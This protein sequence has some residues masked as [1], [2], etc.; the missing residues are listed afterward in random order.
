MSTNQYL[1]ALSENAT[2]LGMRLQESISEHTRDLQQ[3]TRVGGLGLGAGS[4]YL[5]GEARAANDSGN[6]NW[7]AMIKKQLESSSDREKL[8]AMRRLIAMISKNNNSASTYFPSVVKLVASPSLEIRKLVYIYLLHYSPFH[9]DLALLSINTFQR[10]LSDPSPLI[11][12]MALRVLSGM[13]V[14]MLAGVV[15]LGT[16]KCAA[17][18]SPYVRKVA[19]LAI[20]KCYEWVLLSFVL[21]FSDDN[22]LEPSNRPALLQI[23][24]TLL[25]DRSPLALG[26]ALHAFSSICLSP[27]ATFDSSTSQTSQTLEMI[28]SH[29]R[30]YCKILV[31]MDEWGQVVMMR[32]LGRYARVMLPRPVWH[33]RDGEEAEEVEIDKDLKLLLDSV[34]PVL[35][36]QNPAVR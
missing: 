28:H 36:S 9:P 32:V 12:A 23:I 34:K 33:D 29:F 1:T 35:Q 16:K 3:F 17:D 5:D 25:S 31:E 27:V 4:A 15:L 22:S 18:L 21:P 19:G 10:D 14:S 2:R 11:R 20:V 26:A 13:G 7:N 24:Q 30:R 8:D 6:G